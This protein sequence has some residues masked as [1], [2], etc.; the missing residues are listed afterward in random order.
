MQRLSKIANK[1]GTDKGTNYEDSHCYTEFYQQF[2]EK[3][4]HPNILEIGTYLGRSA[5]MFEEFY[6]GDCKIYSCDIIESTGYLE[7]VPTAE[8]IY[9][10]EGRGDSLFE[11]KDRLKDI[12]FDI[13][14]DDASHVWEHQFN[15]LTALHD[16]LA[17][18][19]I[20]VLEDLHYSRLHG[21]DPNVTCNS[22]LYF[23]SFMFPSNSI[24][25]E[26]NEELLSKIEDVYIF[27]H[28]NE[29]TKEMR[30]W[31]GGRSMTAVITFRK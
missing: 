3:Y 7:D 28:R 9:V 13:I 14:I 8:Y 17:D 24:G 18:G 16:M 6:D 11:L 25:N 27:S 10:D 23:L 30:E 31:Y 26:D 15:G 21:E 4:E 20:Y 2:F 19:G 12:K 22:P 29:S 1:V 5:K